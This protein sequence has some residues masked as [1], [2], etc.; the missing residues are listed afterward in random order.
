[1]RSKKAAINASIS[2]IYEIL[3]IVSAFLIPRLILQSFGS[4]TNG[5]TQSVSQFIGYVSL[6]TAG[7]GSV[8]TA[9]LYLPLSQN[10]K[11]EVSSIVNATQSFLRKITR[12]FL[13]ALV[14]FAVVFP[15]FIK[16]FDYFFTFSLVLIL[17]IGTFANYYFG[18]A[19]RMVL[20]ADQKQYVNI[21]IQ[22][23]LLI[24]QTITSVLLMNSGASI[25]VVQIVSALIFAINP[26]FIF[27]YV[28]KKYAINKKTDPNFKAIDQRWDA[29]GH[30]VA[31]FVSNNT[32]LLLL[33]IFSNL[34]EVSVY[35]V[36]ILVLNGIKM[37]IISIITGTTS[38]FGNMFAKKETEAIRRNLKLYEFVLHSLS[39]I[40]YTSMAFLITSF[41]DIYTINIIDA[42][43]HRPLFGYLL[44]AIG[45]FHATR[46]PYESLAKAAGHFK[47]T[48]TGAIIEAVLN[49]VL[50]VSLIIPFGMNGV[51]IGAL[52]ATIYRTI[53]YGFYSSKKLIDRNL[54]V[55]AKRFLVSALNIIVIAAIVI[56][57][58]LK[59]PSTYFEWIVNGLIVTAVGITITIFFSLVFY[60]EDFINLIRIM[61]RTLSHKKLKINQ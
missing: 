31:D 37:V 45:F 55:I 17:G 1:M 38:A 56:F 15:F 10:N 30:Q 4:D 25:H 3:K 27:F 5:I 43:Y 20:E 41:I 14:V 60:Y 13:I 58:P 57:I 40:L 46:L 42:D 26:I 54:K 24:V 48:R 59:L 39:I 44:A 9:A 18:L 47:Q 23:V 6:L 29:F 8:T 2:V 33:T 19:Y 36:Y 49:V 11:N 53:Q 7:V 35:S 51:A 52:V 12:I 16:E 32:G 61:K 34:K 21:I 50:S 22:A 28:G